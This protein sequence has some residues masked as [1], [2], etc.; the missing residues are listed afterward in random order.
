M[1]RSEEGR[2][3]ASAIAVPGAWGAGSAA[4]LASKRSIRTT[5]STVM[6][7]LPTGLTD[8]GAMGGLSWLSLGV[9][10][11]KTGSKVV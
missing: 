9:H 1:V 2:H 10:E 3:S 11:I 7:C 5:E 6:V 4:A 8:G